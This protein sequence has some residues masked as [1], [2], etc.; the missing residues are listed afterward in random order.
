MDNY[1]HLKKT[2][3]LAICIFAIL[4][5]MS[6]FGKKDWQYE[7]LNLRLN[8][9]QQIKGIKYPKGKPVPMRGKKKTTITASTQTVQQSAAAA[10]IVGTVIDTPP[11]D[12]FIPW[13]AVSTTSEKGEEMDM[14]AVQDDT[15][16]TSKATA[17]SPTSDFAIGLFDTGASAHIM[18]YGTSN[19]LGLNN[20]TYL[21]SSTIDVSGV[22]G[23]IPVSVSHPLGIFIQGLG[24]INSFGNLD[25]TQL[26][27]ETNTSIVIGQDPG[28][29]RPDLPTAIGTPLSVYYDTSFNNDNPITFIAD[30]NGVE[31]EY[32]APDI[33]VK[34]KGHASLPQYPNTLPLELRP[35]GALNVQYVISYDFLSFMD[36]PL[37]MTFEAGSPSVV[38]GNS[39][40]SIFFVHSV[41]ITEG[42][43]KASDKDRFMIDTGAQVTVIGRRI[44]ARLGLDENNPD[45]MVEIQGVTGPPTD[46]P[47]FYIDL[48]E[49]PALGEWL[50]FTNVPVILLDVASPE[51]GT[52]DGIIGMNLFTEYNFVLRGGG[53]FL[54]GDPALEF[55]R[56]TSGC[57]QAGD[58]AP[59]GGD[60][61]VDS[62]D[63]AAVA[64]Q[65]LDRSV[66]TAAAALAEPYNDVNIADFAVIA[67]NWLK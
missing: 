49:M 21:T 14:A 4:S 28:T 30:S 45:F 58:I 25:T 16:N 34:T 7:K 38:M 29:T 62:Q 6:A 41:D 51:G 32:T 10:P 1:Y 12:G 46:M 42:A 33:Q 2:I 60:C 26:V 65:W 19:T 23:Y 22:T 9:K 35:L 3:C 63:L 59:A 17:Q 64:E 37:S 56:R 13:I 53:I 66:S 54:T 27:G 24:A 61:T 11:V 39:S 47:G 43:N 20:S 36:D 67:A 15:F 55:E 52:L 8:G 40:Q 5:G 50:R 44:G 57:E 31:V 18:G 48:L